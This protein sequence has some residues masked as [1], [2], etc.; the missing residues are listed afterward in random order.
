MLCENPCGIIADCPS[1][2]PCGSIHPTLTYTAPMKTLLKSLTAL[3]LSTTL[4][5]CGGGGSSTVAALTDTSGSAAVTTLLS[6]DTVV[7][8]GAT[9]ANGTTLSVTYTGYLYDSKV[10]TFKGKSFDTGTISFKLGSGQVITGWDQGIVGMKVG[11][12]RTLIIP[13]ALAYGSTGAGSGLIPANAALVF[14]VELKSV[15]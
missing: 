11:G 6:T 8:T 4:F 10:V 3:A 2:H 9:A 1:F 5:A 13:A 14:D 7:G 12:K 15:N